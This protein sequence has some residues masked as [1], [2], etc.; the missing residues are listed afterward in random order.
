M[1]QP[2]NGMGIRKLKKG[3]RFRV[4]APHA[5][6]V[7]VVGS[8]NNFSKTKHPLQPESGGMWSG[9]V[10][11]AKS[12]DEY[13]YR[14][15]TDDAEY[16]RMDPYSRNVTSSVGNT[17]IHK[18]NYEWG[19]YSYE[20]P[21][22]NE[23]IIYEIHIGTFAHTSKDHPGTLVQ[24][25]KRLDYLKELGI[26]A[27]EIMPIMEFAGG[28]SW[29]YNPSFIFAIES[30][31]GS[32]AQFRDFVN[33]AHELNIAV[34]LDVVYNHFGP[35][36][37]DL[38]QFDGWQENDKGGIYFYNDWKSHTPWGETR[39][40]YGR[41]EVR[42]YLRDNALFWLEEYRIDG[43]RW[44]A[45][46]FIRNVKGQDNDPAHDIPEGW[47]LM[48][49]INEEIFALY[50]KA[51][52]IA[53]DL[54]DNA[55]L[56]KGTEEGGAGFTGQWDAG[57]VHPVRS[58]LIKAEDA[59]RDMHAIKEAIEY[60]ISGDAF[61]RIIY[62]ESHDEVANGKARLPEEVDPG[63]ADSYFA[64][65]KS[66]LGAALVFTSPGIPM[67]FQGQEF[68]E[69]DWFHDQDPV[70]WTKKERFKGIWDLYKRL[71]H[72]RLD[73]D[74]VTSGLLASNIDVYHINQNDKVICYHRWRSGGGGDSVVIIAN[75]SNQT[76]LS[77]EIGLPHGGRWRVR[78]NS[79]DKRYDEQFGN[80]DSP[81]IEAV[82][83]AR[84]GYDFKGRIN[85]APFSF[86]ILS[87]DQ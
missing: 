67:I 47:S 52:S 79:D 44:D 68:L 80:L 38:W 19:H 69:D 84:D 16:M 55:Y 57:F 50:P 43:L 78:L 34:I 73:R 81:D 22:L 87:G 6:N 10:S 75:F 7:F 62:T 60:S 42:E 59:H 1:K 63:R 13:R 61:K 21:A 29:G 77:Y 70:D 48:Q 17:I 35:S 20:R 71:I 5:S 18:P 26:N 66:C 72:L 23:L 31:Y 83:E 8:F 64:K 15:V 85:L 25:I 2:I 46:A 45:T 58:E 36:D 39:P 56:T 74:K 65:K 86:I 41:K 33:R 49:W 28:Y 12:G 76:F 51:L 11:N 82:Q 24:A 30:D 40:D 9:T 37:L 32:P 27:I 4:W 3:Y 54:K 53:E 14:I